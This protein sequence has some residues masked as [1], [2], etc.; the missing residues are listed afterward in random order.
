MATDITIEILRNLQNGQSEIKQ[1]INSLRSDMTLLLAAI[2]EKLSGQLLAELEYRN[3]IN[4]L[5]E[6][7]QRVEKRLELKG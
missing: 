2:N 6:R 5:R 3:E 4:E 7:L 1:G